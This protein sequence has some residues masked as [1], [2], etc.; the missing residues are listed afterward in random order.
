MQFEHLIAI[1]DPGNPLIMPLS[2]QQVWAGLL[3]RVENP[4]PFLP[5]LEACAILER[6]ADHL[7]RELDFGAARIRDRVTQAEAHW[8]R[9][10]IEPG[11]QYAGGSL[12]ITIEEPEAGHLFLR[13]AYVTGFAA[14]AGSEERAYVEYI[15]SAYQQSD[16]D[17]VRIIRTLAAGDNQQ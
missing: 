11:E 3:H 17:C 4:L 16:I 7:V 5:G 1:N 13:F 8:V 14:A 2:R 9:F 6:H 12:T 15:K 10:D